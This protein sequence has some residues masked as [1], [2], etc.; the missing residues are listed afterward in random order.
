MTSIHTER[1][2]AM[3]WKLKRE[4]SNFA[5]Q[6]ALRVVQN[7]RFTLIAILLFINTNKRLNYTLVGWFTPQAQIDALERLSFK[8]M[9]N[10]VRNNYADCKAVAII[11]GNIN[12]RNAITV[13]KNF[14]RQI[15]LAG[16]YHDNALYLRRTVSFPKPSNLL[17]TVPAV[18]SQENA[19]LV[20]YQIGRLSLQ[21]RMT[22]SGLNLNY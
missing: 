5:K 15:S 22:F 2:E 6:Q 16:P 3:R 19:I 20:V 11:A 4:L 14:F 21:D 9:K 13:A 7:E 17:V 8:S 18:Y 1:F 12:E 10:Y